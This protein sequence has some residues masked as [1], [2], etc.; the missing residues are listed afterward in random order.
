MDNFI[1][2]T[3]LLSPVTL[4]DGFDASLPLKESKVNEEVYDNI[5]YSHMY[6]FGRDTR[7]G[8]VRIYGVYARN[9]SVKKKS[10]KAGLL[11]IP[12]VGKTVDTDIVNVYVKQGYAVLMID[13]SGESPDLE[14]YTKYPECV[15][16]A[17]Y[18][19]V[20]RAMDHC[21]ETAEKT[22]WYEWVAVARYGISFLRSQFELEK[23]GVLGIK[24]GA[25]IGWMVCGTD[26]RVDCF[27]PLFGMGWRTYR[28]VYKY[29]DKEMAVDDEKLRFLAAVDSHAYVQYVTCP[30]FYMTATNSADFDCDRAMD[31][32]MRFKGQ[33]LY[34][35]L[36]P[37]ADKV[38]DLSCKSDID[39]FLAKYL[40]GFKVTMPALPKINIT[41]KEKYATATVELDFSDLLRPKNVTVYL[42]EDGE[43]PAFRDWVIMAP[44]K[45]NE[46]NKKSFGSEMIGNSNFVNVFAVAEYKNGVTV[47]SLM[48]C[49]KIPKTPSR[50][51]N[52]VYSS[53]DK[54]SS[55]A[56]SYPEKV[57][58]GGLFFEDQKPVIF[59][60][61][62]NKI[63]GVGS[64][65]G[66]ISYKFN[67][68]KVELNERSLIVMDVNTERYSLL[69]VTLVLEENGKAT[70]YDFSIALSG[71]GIWQHVI[72]RCCDFKSPKRISIKDY[73]AVSAMKLE[74]GS[75]CIFNN[76][77]II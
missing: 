24:S 62:S 28:G 13:Y 44:L 54:T 12:D 45:G 41:C 49:K 57:A 69:K 1:R 38:L 29:S 77:L 7:Q 25:D 32:L 47:S 52:L 60:E 26:R 48:T 42:A 35:N 50:K 14:H 65:Y 36:S 21:D 66:L 67:V 76:I 33:S 17:N 63:C 9:K 68:R 6:F 5:V 43:N 40:L 55:F 4:W 51:L 11:I 27:V 30:I 15:S 20:G 58:L 37:R 72:I 71:G 34:L 18:L 19:K 8:R 10:P 3:E 61:G 53:N 56:A 64:E 31:T 59:V 73:S 75:L 46:E 74:S 70:D 16:Y 2:K 22:A 39:I 23:V